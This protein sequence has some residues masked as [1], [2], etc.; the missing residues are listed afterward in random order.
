MRLAA[1]SALG[2]I[3]SPGALQALDRALTDADR[4]V[5]VQAARALL[6]RRYQAAL[7]RVEATVQSKRLR[8]A[9]R[10]ERLAFFELYG[11]LCGDGGVEFL[12]KLLN[13]KGGL[14]ARRDP[15]RVAGPTAARP[16]AGDAL[17]LSVADAAAMGLQAPL[18]SFLD[19]RELLLRV[20]PAGAAAVVERA[21]AAGL[22]RALHGA[23]V[24][25][26]WFFPAVAERATQLTPELP[27]LERKAVAAIVEAARDPARLRRVRGT[28]EA[29]RL[30][31][32]PV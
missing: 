25:T 15:Y 8:E 16:S 11:M 20:E 23:L 10:T 14:F 13:F 30:L 22:S 19:L 27:A 7:Q 32:S 26:A 28:E 29:A 5:R 3:A 2:E 17:L 21:A 12:D 31:L 9:D 4:D 18:L 6:N 1:L 24:L